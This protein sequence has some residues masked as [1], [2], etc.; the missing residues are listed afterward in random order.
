MKLSVG[1]TMPDFAVSMICK[2]DISMKELVG[3]TPTAVYF[4]RYAGCTLCQLDMITIHEEYSK[5]LEAGAK[6]LVVIQSPAEKLKDADFAY[7]II[8][9]PS[10]ALYK[11]LE[12]AAAPSV[13]VLIGGSTME[14]IERS[15]ARGFVHG[16]Y[17][18]EELQLPA[19]FI[20]DKDL[21]VIYSRYAKDLS[22]IPDMDEVCN[23]I[24]QNA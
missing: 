16:E 9:D 20:V 14:K 4:L 8:C 10:M 24:R 21:K 5:L 3:G 15:K 18:G 7:D 12:I 13:E 6:A 23:V 1:N 2:G 19:V 11:E 17:E 22:D